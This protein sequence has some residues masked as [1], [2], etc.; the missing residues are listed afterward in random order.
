ML[1]ARKN[2]MP[3]I[4]RIYDYVPGDSPAV[5]VDRLYPRGIRKEVMTKVQW[6]KSLAPSTELR[7]WYHADM[8]SRATEFAE[9][10]LQELANPDLQADL[11][12]FRALLSSSPDVVILTA[13]KN[14][15]HSH[16]PLLLQAAG[17]AT[18]RIRWPASPAS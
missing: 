15:Q 12:A 3:Y 16:V 6:L 13:V 2:A 9:R 1:P 8:E 7:R 11:A 4:Q 18:A 10:Y 17:V 14:P 5:F